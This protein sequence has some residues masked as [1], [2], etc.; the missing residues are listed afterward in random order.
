MSGSRPPPPRLRLLLTGFRAFGGEPV[1]P[2]EQ[3]VRDLARRPPP[4]PRLSLH[5]AILPVDRTLFRPA[6]QAALRRHRPQLVVSVGQATGRGLVELEATAHNLL[7]YR[8]ERDNGGFTASAERLHA[9]GCARVHC[10]LPLAEL[11]A[12]LSNS[13]LPVSVSQDAGRHLCNA[14]LYELLAEHAGLPACFV[15]VPLLPEQAARRGRGEP[16][17]PW[18]VSRQCLAALLSR[19]PG[20]LPSAPRA[21]CPA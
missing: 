12:E 1:N 4:D 11:A 8:G 7:D 20:H 15:H 18:A 9:Q 6:L 13:G 2:S 5:V 19:L 10:R 21:A 14:L 17:L 16:S 3:L